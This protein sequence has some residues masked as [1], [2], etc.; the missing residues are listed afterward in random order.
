[1]WTDKQAV[2]ILRQA[3]PDLTVEVHMEE[4]TEVF[5]RIA[6][7]AND[8]QWKSCDT[9]NR[10]KTLT[11]FWRFYRQMESCAANIITPDL[12]DASGAV[13]KTSKEK[14]SALLQNFVKQSNQNNLH[15]RKAVLKR[16]YRTMTETGSNDYL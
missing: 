7:E 1:M 13:L 4:N 6:S 3:T 2:V 11:H 15:E 10:D 8:R 12:I 5:K 16:L 14:G 9:L